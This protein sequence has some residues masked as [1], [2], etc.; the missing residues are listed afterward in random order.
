MSILLDT[1]VLLWWLDNPEILT[2]ATRQA[3]ADPM[4]NV[5]VSA[6]SYMEIV[7]KQFSGKLGI[8]KPWE[9]AIEEAR[10]TQ[11][12]FSSAHAL[13]VKGLPPIHK[14]PFD[15]MLVAQAMVERATLATADKMLA[16]Y[17][18]PILLA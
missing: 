13:A 15:R 18:I 5:Y 2:E 17:G 4:R 9:T 3:I 10:F 7:I 11:L 12:S 14:D 16:D 6:I 1:N 8:D